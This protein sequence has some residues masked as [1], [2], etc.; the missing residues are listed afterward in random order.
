MRIVA[1]TLNAVT[2]EE[3]R[4]LI[5]ESPDEE[6]TVTCGGDVY[7]WNCDATSYGNGDAT[8]AGRLLQS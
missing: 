6:L 5:E 8:V 2:E 7:N 3:L 1:T 4:L